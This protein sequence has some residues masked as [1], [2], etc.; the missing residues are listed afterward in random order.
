MLDDFEEYDEFG[1]A[2]YGPEFHDP[3]P[4]PA[5]QVVP[6]MTDTT[7]AHKTSLD[8]KFGG[9]NFFSSLNPKNANYQIGT[10]RANSPSELDRQKSIALDRGINRLK[11]PDSPNPGPHQGPRPKLFDISGEGGPARENRSSKEKDYFKFQNLPTVPKFRMWRLRF[12]RDIASGSIDPKRAMVW[13]TEVE[14]AQSWEELEDD[15]EFYT[16][17]AK[18]A[19]GLIIIMYGE[20]GRR[21]TIL[22]DQLSRKGEMLNGRQILWIIYQRFRVHKTQAAMLTR[23]HLFAIKL[24]N[25]NLREFL[26][27]WDEVMLEMT[28]EVD[29]GT[30]AMQFRKGIDQATIMKD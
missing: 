8:S 24:S 9:S 7:E 23:E 4:E 14:N 17:S 29:E 6:K 2:D 25:D 22:D 10:G 27:S 12:K 30:L 28:D 18:I 15:E 19:A 11:G 26:N 1:E 21:I 5:K 16:L 3:P 20:L 13:I